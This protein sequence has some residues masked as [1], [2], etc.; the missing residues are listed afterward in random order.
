MVRRVEDL[1][2]TFEKGFKGLRIEVK[3]IRKELASMR[4]ELVER[5]RTSESIKESMGSLGEKLGHLNRKLEGFGDRYQRVAAEPSESE[6]EALSEHSHSKESPHRRSQ[7]AHT[8]AS[9]RADWRQEHVNG[10]TYATAN[11]INSVNSSRGRRSV[12]AEGSGTGGRK[13]GERSTRR[14]PVP[15]IGAANA[16]VPDIRDHPAYRRVTEA[17]GLSSPVYQTPN[18]E[19]IWY[20]EAFGRRQ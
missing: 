14:E 1:Q 15:E 2:E 12:T 18:Y 5:P 6:R 4:K 8:S 17:H 16:Q 11:T 3:E 19:E 10:T 13:S 9:S 7:S 20:Q